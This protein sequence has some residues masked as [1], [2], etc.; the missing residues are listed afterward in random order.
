MT[1]RSAF[2]TTLIILLIILAAACTRIADLQRQIDDATWV[3]NSCS[4][5]DNPES[6]KD[7]AK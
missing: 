6:F 2:I 7:C 1:N 3:Y 5:A 4:P